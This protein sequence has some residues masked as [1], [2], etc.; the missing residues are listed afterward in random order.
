MPVI[1]TL[2]KLDKDTLV[3]ILTKP[4]NALVKQYKHLFKIDDVDL[5]I[6]QEALELIAEKAL[7]INTGARGLRGILENIM[8]DVMYELPSRQDVKKCIITKETILNNSEP[9]LILNNKA[10]QKSINKENAS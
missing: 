10:S 8:L 3:K 6:E 1:V 7:E 9:I 4:K 5:E 2:D